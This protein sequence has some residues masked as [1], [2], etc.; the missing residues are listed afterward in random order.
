MKNKLIMYILC[1]YLFACCKEEEFSIQYD[2]HGVITSMPWLWRVSTTE[3]DFIGGLISFP[4]YYTG[5][6]LLGAENAGGN[7]YFCF[8][9]IKNGAVR[10]KQDYIHETSLFNVSV[11]YIYRENLIVRDGHSIF[12][13]NLA[14]GEYN[15]KVRDEA[16]GNNWLSGIDSLYFNINS[17]TDPLTG[18]P[19]ASAYV[20]NTETGEQELFLIPD[21]GELLIPDLGRINFAIGGFRFLKPFRNNSSG[22]IMLSCYYSKQYYLQNSEEQISKSFL[23]LYNFS[24][25]VWIYERVEMGDYNFLEGFTPAVIGDRLYHT[26]SEGVAEC[27]NIYTGEVIWRNEDDYQYNWTSFVIAGNKMIVMDDWYRNLIAYDIA[28]GNEVWRVNTTSNNDYMQEL[29]GVVYFSSWGDGRI[30]AVEAETGKYLW[31]LQSPDEED[32]YM[33]SFIP[34]C[35]VIPG[36]NGEKGRVVVSSNTHAYCYEAAR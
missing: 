2:E 4:I 13:L 19:V 24:K 11:P 18:Y 10:W 30:H 22:E 6:V 28:T 3:H 34:Q 26:L 16:W 36:V 25:K 5:G 23:G 17:I 21:L 9:E 7:N 27:R 20:G 1:S 33:D 12:N 31:H 32:N 8:F 14:S 29:N 15:W 35:T